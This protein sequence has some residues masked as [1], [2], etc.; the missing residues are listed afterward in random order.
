MTET[1]LTEGAPATTYRI[2]AI[3]SVDDRGQI[4]LPKELR[5]RAGLQPGDKIALVGFEDR[6]DLCCISFFKV[7]DLSTLVR[8]KLE[9]IMKGAF[10][11]D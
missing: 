10:S 8:A 2:E 4:L 9:P 7:D 5:E 1:Q 11:R 3:V 6:G